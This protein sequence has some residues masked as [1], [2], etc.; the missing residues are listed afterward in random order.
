MEII[1]I[2]PETIR[3][4]KMTDE[5]YF[6]NAEYK[7]YVSNSSLSRLDPDNDGSIE[8]YLKGFDNKYSE[9]FELGSAIH[10]MILQPDEYIISPLDK[11]TAKLGVFV[12]NVFS[13]RSQG[14]TIAKAISIAR[15]ESDYYASS[16]SDLKFKTAVSKSIKYYLGR[17]HED[18]E[19]ITKKVL[20]LPA[21]MKE[22]VQLCVDSIRKDSKLLEKLYPKGIFEDALFFNE[23]A[24]FCDIKVKIDEEEIIL[25]LKAKLDNF[26]INGEEKEITLNDL[27]T[28]GKPAKFFMG[29]YISHYDQDGNKSK[30]W[31][32]G[33]FQ[34]YKYYRQMG[35]Y[36][37]LLSAYIKATYNYDYTLKANMLLVETIPDYN[38][39]VCKV[40]NSAIKAG[41]D[42][43]KRLIIILSKWM[44]AAKQRT[45]QELNT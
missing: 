21:P 6:N 16:W 37:W 30:V 18:K 45:Q 42:D 27:K 14:Y 28:T 39:R 40:N 20:Y 41:L 35:M 38:T 19:L 36:L 17:L 7:D 31:I 25:K 9:A 34:K 10:C 32:N 1:T 23:Y 2:I 5:E 11:P 29:N 3:L 12:D 44:I 33:S 26:T 13:L 8:N 4:I 43:F 24:L 15:K 22:K